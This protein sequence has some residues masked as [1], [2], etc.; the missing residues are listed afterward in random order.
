MH[1]VN[2]IH[3]LMALKEISAEFWF[4]IPVILLYRT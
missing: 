3:A 4:V 2:R 1:T